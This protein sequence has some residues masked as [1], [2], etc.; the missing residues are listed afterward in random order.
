MPALSQADFL[1]LIACLKLCLFLFLILILSSGL[2]FLSHAAFSSCLQ[3]GNTA[4]I[5]ASFKGHTATVE[6][7][8]KKGA[9]TEEKND[10]S[11]TTFIIKKKY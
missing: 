2:F 6:L 7:L 8:L 1:Y 10:V 5:Y 4:L 11:Y 9:H 3:S